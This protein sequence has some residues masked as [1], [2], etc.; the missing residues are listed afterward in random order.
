MTGLL[1]STSRPQA[2]QNGRQDSYRF[3][4]YPDVAQLDVTGSAQIFS[5]RPRQLGCAKSAKNPAQKVGVFLGVRKYPCR[6]EYHIIQ[7]FK[8]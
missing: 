6:M 1:P 5:A 7:W 3:L 2:V 4:I 8:A